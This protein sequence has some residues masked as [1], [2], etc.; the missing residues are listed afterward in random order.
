MELHLIHVFLMKVKIHNV[1]IYVHKQIK[2]K[3]SIF[4]K[5]DLWKLWLLGK[6]CNKKYIQMD[7]LLLVLSFG[8]T[9]IITK[10]AF[11]IKLLENLLEVMLWGLLVG[12]MMTKIMEVYIG[13]AKTNGLQIGEK[14]DIS[15]S[16]QE[17]SVLINGL[18]VVK[19]IILIFDFNSYYLLK[20]Y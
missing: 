14:K 9:C 5:Q 13:F 3:I 2:N 10:E 8:K 1:R 16:K 4:V 12:V 17:W 18:L 20:F 19:Q 7:Q 6:K 11:I 15:K